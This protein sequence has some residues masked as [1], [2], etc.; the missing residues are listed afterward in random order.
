MCGNVIPAEVHRN[1]AEAFNCP[2]E[3][4]SSVNQFGDGKSGDE[5]HL[6]R[7][8][9]P[10]NLENAGEY[11]LKIKKASSICEFDTEINS[12]FSA[13]KN[14]YSQKIKIPELKCFSSSIGYYVY[15]VAG[16]GAKDTSTLCA[17]SPEKKLSR[18]KEIIEESFFVWSK[19]HSTVNASPSEMVQGWLGEKRLA[20]DARLA[21]RIRGFIHDELTE[22][23]KIED[24]VLPNPYCYFTCMFTGEK[25]IVLTNVLQGPQHGD[26]NQKNI[27][28]QPFENGYIY[29]YIDF[30]HYHNQTFLFFDQAYLLLDLLLTIDGL[31]L[32]DWINHIRAFFDALVDKS[33]IPNSDVF[34]KYGNSFLDG[35]RRFY[36]RFPQNGTTLV[37]QMLCAC[38]A[39][40]LNFAN[41]STAPVNKQIFSFVFSSLALEKMIALRVGPQPNE[42]GDYPK[43]NVGT[44]DRISKLWGVVDAFSP[45]TRYVLLS[46]CLPDDIHPDLF[47]SMAPIPWTA[48]IEV[49]GFLESDLRNKALKKFRRRHSYRHVLLTDNSEILSIGKEAVWCSLVINNATKN[50][51]IFYSKHIQSRLCAYLKS[52]LDQ[53]E[54]YPLCVLVDSRHMDM[55]IGNR[56]LTDLMV[57]AGENTMIDIVNLSDL[58]VCVD[59][60]AY[61]KVHNIPCDL[62]E[63]ALNI[64]MSFKSYDDDEIMLP[65]P[66]GPVILE[67]S[68]A[69]EI[70]CDMKII[71][72]KLTNVSDDDQGEAFY[73]GGEATWHDISFQRDVTRFDYKELWYDRIHHKLEHMPSSGSSIIRLYHKPGGGGSTMAKRIMWDFC[74]RYPTVHLKKIFDQTAERLKMLYS[75][76]LSMPLLIIAEANGGTIYSSSLSSLRADLIKKNVR[77]LFICV[78]RRNE[79]NEGDNSRDFYLPDT[80]QMYISVASDEATAMCRSFSAR[81]DPE[82]DE[83]RLGD[84]SD[85][86]YSDK[87]GNDLRQ[88][89]FY[90]LFAFGEDYQKIEEYVHTNLVNSEERENFLLKILAFNT[91][92]SQDVNLN[93]REISHILYP[94]CPPTRDILDKTRSVLSK[95]CF[96]VHRNDGYRVSH[97][98]IARKILEHF[99]DDL[100]GLAKELVECLG[101]YYSYSSPRL[102]SIFHELFIHREPI[103]EDQ[104]MVFSLFITELPDDIR[105]ISFMNYLRETFPN[106]PHYCNHL[107]RIYLKPQDE[108]LWPD[109][110]NAKKYAKEAIERAES[111]HGDLGA[112]HH[113]LM[114]KVY[115]RDC[116]SQLRKNFGRMHV[117]RAVKEIKPIYWEAIREFNISFYGK[118]SSYSLVGKLELVTKIFETISQKMHITISNLLI[119]EQSLRDTLTEMISEAG[120][121]VHQYTDNLDDSVTAFRSAML[122]FYRV[123]GKLKEIETV[124]YTQEQN[125]RIRANSRRSIATILEANARGTDTVLSYNRLNEPTLMRIKSLMEENIY[126]DSTVIN[127]DLFR[128]LEAYR[129][130]DSFNLSKAYQL[131]ADWPETN[132]DLDVAYYRYVLAF[133]FYAKHYG[134]AYQ[135]VKE[136]LVRCQQLSEKA[137]GKYTTVSKDLLG[138]LDDSDRAAIAPWQQYEFGMSQED[139]ETKN[140]EYREAFCEFITGTISSISDATLGI[141]FSMEEMG[142]ALLYAKAPKSAVGFDMLDGQQVKFHLGFSYSG[143]RAWDIMPLE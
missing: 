4:L 92:Y 85:L 43:L 66:S 49:N 17:Q 68:K 107:A 143:F 124:F 113:H 128:W 77:A 93:L 80:P 12:T 33:A 42:H 99:G 142:Y 41:K 30:S 100:I 71:H 110:T 65:S 73:R 133:L 54:K 90:G 109:I 137:R 94:D 123:M 105:R 114:G 2:V 87:Y 52:V 116:I 53:N 75:A 7:V 135:T 63:I 37:C 119:R 25:D 79:R 50:K 46:P 88:P 132:E 127:S 102:D 21:E 58:E 97:P 40:G 62:E 96:I 108:K 11:I 60:E 13:R 27:L 19:N 61:I 86:T 126:T 59:D 82:Q 89:F 81:L 98:L 16:I 101:K 18:F 91:T 26:L 35:W 125:P 118:N 140:R 117:N 122:R 5:V 120:N 83:N 76:C 134:V 51:D 10:A 72:R 103:A 111:Q 34:F 69:N 131:V 44:T 112:I 8:T 22:A 106:N 9:N 95:N 47:C 15:D 104:R 141:R 56:I 139:R 3:A 45:P 74:V 129:H 115:S 121:V 67:I 70:E 48:I 38:A 138:R 31:L 6:I 130:L 55:R 23:W 39:A 84:L 1:V 29:Y 64:Q 20:H 57:A 28:I 32:T 78:S 24:L 36:S 14:C 136:H